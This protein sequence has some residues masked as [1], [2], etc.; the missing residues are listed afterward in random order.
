MTRL[1]YIDSFKVFEKKPVSPPKQTAETVDELRNR[2]TGQL[3]HLYGAIPLS[4]DKSSVVI[5]KI[6]ANSMDGYFDLGEKV[7]IEDSTPYDHDKVR[8][9]DYFD[10]LLSDKDSRGHNF[11]GTLAGLFDGELSKRGEKWDVTIDDKTWS[12]K[13]I[14]HG[15]KAPELGSYLKSLSSTDLIN[16]IKN[17][18]GLTLLF[19]F[20]SDDL[21]TKVWEVISAGIT[22]GWIIGYPDNDLGEI[23]INILSLDAMKEILMSGLTVSPKGGKKELFNLAISSKFKNFSQ[24]SSIIIPQISLSSLI[25]MCKSEDEYKW[26]HEVFGKIGSK[27]RPDVLRYIKTNAEFIGNN[28]LKTKKINNFK[29]N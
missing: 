19:K 15:A 23:N 24:K 26:A 27:I 4:K 16:D 25:E 9:K 28:L 7:N 12:V 1:N 5:K 13:F 10:T 17:E 22:G 6:L 18:G 11:E 14:D 2:L 3:L 20:G 8:F 29:T 21:K